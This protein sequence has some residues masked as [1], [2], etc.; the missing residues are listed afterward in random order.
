MNMQKNPMPPPYPDV[1]DLLTTTGRARPEDIR[2]CTLDE[3]S[4]IRTARGGSLHPQYE[5]F[6]AVMGGGAGILLR[7]TDFF[8]PD[9]VNIGVEGIELLTDDDALDLLPAGS[10]LVGLHGGSELYW[11]EPDG[12][13]RW[14]KEGRGIYRSWPSFPEFLLAQIRAEVNAAAE[15]ERLRRR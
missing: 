4:E 12:T 10:T 7:G 14:Y 13:V 9:V 2:P 6:L 5:Q 8:H 15:L 11:I 1:I 3:I